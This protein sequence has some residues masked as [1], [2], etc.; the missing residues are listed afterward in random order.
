MAIH[1][2]KDKLLSDIQDEFHAKFPYLKIEF[3]KKG[4]ELHESTAKSA[5]LDGGLTIAEAGHFDHEEDLSIDGH[6]KVAT[7]EALFQDHFGIGAQVFRKSGN[8][9]IQTTVTDDW[10]LAHQNRDGQEDST[11]QG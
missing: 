1:I 9:W 4:H 3:F 11:F 5:R 7:L 10:T 2:T 8:A 6:L